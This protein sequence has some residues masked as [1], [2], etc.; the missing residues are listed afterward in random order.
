MTLQHKTTYSIDEL[1]MSAHINL[2]RNASFFCQVPKW[3]AF[4]Q[5]V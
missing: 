5:G 2:S 1:E 3:L 4:Q